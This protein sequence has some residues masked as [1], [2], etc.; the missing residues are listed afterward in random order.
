MNRFDG[1]A[2]SSAAAQTR[3]VWRDGVFRVECEGAGPGQGQRMTLRVF[4]ERFL[5]AEENVDSA[6]SA[7]QRGSDIC[8]QLS[9]GDLR[10]YGN[11]PA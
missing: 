11:G 10:A 5:M 1:P 6:E 4:Y 7:W 9:S 2:G 3:I 8:R